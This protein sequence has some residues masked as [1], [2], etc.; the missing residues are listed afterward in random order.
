MVVITHPLAGIH[1]TDVA[2][3]AAEAYEQVMRVL[4]QGEGA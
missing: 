4:T 2:D 1:D 3:R